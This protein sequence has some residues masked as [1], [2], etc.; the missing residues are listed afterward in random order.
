[1]VAKNSSCT[2]TQCHNHASTWP[3]KL[4]V[5]PQLMR[6]TYTPEPA[7]HGLRGAS[8]SYLKST[9]A[10]NSG[11]RS[12]SS[13][14]PFRSEYSSGDIGERNRL[15]LRSTQLCCGIVQLC[16]F[17]QNR[18]LRQA[19]AIAQDSVGQPR[20]DLHGLRIPVPNI[21]CNRLQRTS[22]RCAPSLMLHGV[23]LRI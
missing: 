18:C 1:M 3:C 21:P 4:G 5:L 19:C 8:M 10:R 17:R 6:A 14:Q 13:M 15:W 22:S 23:H 16:C 12:C 2:S 7:W 9:Y 11:H 20:R